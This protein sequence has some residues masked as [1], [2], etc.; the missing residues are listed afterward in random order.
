MTRVGDRHD[1]GSVV[2]WR[3]REGKGDEVRLDVLFGAHE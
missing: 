1:D 3:D 2:R